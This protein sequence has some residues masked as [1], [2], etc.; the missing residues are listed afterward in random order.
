[1]KH[2]T[3]EEKMQLIT[4]TI[5]SLLCLINVPLGAIGISY[6]LFTYFNLPF[7]VGCLLYFIIYI[8]C[9]VFSI[10][11]LTKYSVTEGE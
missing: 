10:Y 1:M 9:L 6:L 5:W 11:I 3:H 4:I 7:W 8:C 2:Y